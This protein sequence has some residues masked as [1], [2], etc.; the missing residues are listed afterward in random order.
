MD[1]VGGAGCNHIEHVSTQ[2][3]YA[4][5]VAFC[6]T[7]GYVVAGF[8]HGNL[9]ASFGTALGLMVVLATALHFMKTKD[10]KAVAA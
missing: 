5:L 4:L 1:V 3:P 8:T 10:K 2:I 7:A 6:S 9:V